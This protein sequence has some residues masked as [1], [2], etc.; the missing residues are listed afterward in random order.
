M[1]SH[2]GGRL[3]TFPGTFVGSWMG[4]GALPRHNANLMPVYSSRATGTAPGIPD[5]CCPLCQEAPAHAH[6]PLGIWQFLVGSSQRMLPPGS[7][8]GSQWAEPLA[9]ISWAR[10]ALCI[11]RFSNLI[12]RI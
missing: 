2:I 11:S 10:A 3:I 6:L 4:S 12:L 7:F 8:P 9:W 5:S 1:V